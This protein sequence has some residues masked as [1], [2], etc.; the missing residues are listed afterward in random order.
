MY[1]LQ[2]TF[3]VAEKSSTC[4]TKFDRWKSSTGGS[5]V[6]MPPS[7]VVYGEDGGVQ[8]DDDTLAGS[9]PEFD[10]RGRQRRPLARAAHSLAQ[11]VFQ[12]PALEEDAESESA[13]RELEAAERVEH[14]RAMRAASDAACEARRADWRVDLQ[15]GV[16]A[17]AH[18]WRCASVTID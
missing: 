15:P 8:S 7:L 5:Y 10:E 6:T 13:M 1:L 14:A 2:K 3:S 16:C 9:S 17:F 18:V 4:R 11:A 12:Q